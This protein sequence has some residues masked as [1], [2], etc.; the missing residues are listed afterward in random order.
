VL[1]FFAGSGTTGAAAAK[2][3]RGFV[4]V[5]ESPAAVRVMAERLAQYAPEVPEPD[6]PFTASGTPEVP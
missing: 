2:H 5:D 1:D 6:L 3:G 4:L